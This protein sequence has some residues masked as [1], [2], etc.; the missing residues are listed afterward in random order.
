MIRIVRTSDPKERAQRQWEMYHRVQD[1]WE[2]ANGEDK[3]ESPIPEEMLDLFDTVFALAYEAL[4]AA[5]EP[6]ANPTDCP[7]CHGR[8]SSFRRDG[9]YTSRCPVCRRDPMKGSE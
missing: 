8:N 2:W 4:E 6:M 1:A 7:G 5:C 9:S 3:E